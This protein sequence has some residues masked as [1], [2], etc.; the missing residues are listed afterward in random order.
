MEK[1]YTASIITVSDKGFN[2]LR[3]DLSGKEIKKILLDKGYSIDSYTIVPDEKD[4][5]KIALLDAVKL[6]SNLI[7]TTGGTGFSTRDVTPEATEDILDKKAIGISEAIL[8]YS[9]S[10]TPRAMLSRGVAGIKNSS[11]IINLPGSPKAVN[12]CLSYI[13]DT[14]KHG[15]DILTGNAAECAR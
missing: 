7:L 10:N 4:A 6:N 11:L 5:I 1:H 3:D 2:K 9:L 8:F 13:I 15:I 14:L 12:E